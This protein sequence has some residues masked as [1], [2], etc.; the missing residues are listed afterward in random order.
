[1]RV[2]GVSNLLFI[3]LSLGGERDGVRGI[4]QFPIRFDRD[5]YTLLDLGNALYPEWP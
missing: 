1:M 5:I 4:L 2:L 3:A